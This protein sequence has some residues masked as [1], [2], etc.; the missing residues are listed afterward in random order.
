MGH[1]VGRMATRLYPEGI[2]IEEDHLHH[3]EAV[4]STLTAME[5]P[6]IRAIYEAGFVHD[7]VR[8]NVLERLGDGKWSL[9]RKGKKRKKK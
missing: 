3:E 1:E 9:R 5:N 4:Q 6:D 2:L 8:V 7:G